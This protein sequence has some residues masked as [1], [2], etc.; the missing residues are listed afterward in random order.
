[1]TIGGERSKKNVPLLRL[2][3]T[4]GRSKKN[5]PLLR[6]V[7]M[8]S[9]LKDIQDTV[10]TY[11]K[12]IS[13]I[14]KVDVEIVDANLYRI[15]GTGVFESKINEDMSCEG[16]VYKTVLETGEP[17]LIEE[18]GN[19]PLCAACPKRQSCEE[20]LELCTPIKLNNEIIGVIGLICFDNEQK[21][22]LLR[23]LDVYREFLDQI[24]GFISIKAY[25][26]KE[27]E[28]TSMLMKLLNV[29]IDNMGKGVLIL[30]K[31]DRIVHING[32][33][34]KQLFLTRDCLQKKINIEATG[35]NI[36]GLDEFKV[37][38]N[39]KVF[40]LMGDML[41]VIP[42]VAEYA[43]IL[44]FNEMKEVKSKIYDLT[45]I[46][47]EIRLDH[48]L[49]EAE[50]M[51]QLK[52]KILKIAESKSTVLITGESG[53]GKELVARAIYTES[54][55]HSQPFVAI[56]CGAIPDTL[57][58]SELFGYVKGA[59]TG[60]DP[61]GKIGKFELANKGVIFLDEVGDMPLYLQVKLLRVLQERKITRIG[62]NQQIDIDVRVIAATNKNLVPMI[63]ENKFR[64]DLYYRL[65][66]IP[67]E[68]PPLRER[69]EDIRLIAMHLIEKYSR[70]FDKKVFGIDEDAI[71]ELI[72]YPWPGNVRELENTIEFM[73]N[74]VDDMGSLT[75]ET[76]PNNIQDYIAKDIP[77]NPVERNY[78]NCLIEADS[79]RPIKE[80]ERMLIQK[81]LQINGDTTEGKQLAAKQLG[82]GIATLYRRI[83][84]YQLSK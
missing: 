60:A 42:R 39:E 31:D 56:N 20:K 82:I 58:E 49:G 43:K 22:H 44:I 16:F 61:R 26:N 14:I 11:A 63:A 24:A 46:A 41:P 64:E 66:V 10:I 34:L 57:L 68:I 47:N 12:I 54:V 4:A 67:L 73:I 83:E 2:K 74:M 38:L 48:I 8:K 21:D 5:V 70:L 45:N 17:Q 59:F 50:V 76:L 80:M 69:K 77:P 71:R 27:N 3:A 78:D 84:E 52:R 35:D 19:H 55:R 65:N 79:I 13:H 28:R 18:P 9:V 29:V 51:R 81:A 15:A 75:K 32:S 37:T 40:Y 36:L 72:D 30:D 1:M 7:I 33:A 62:S 23:E 6:E 25:E 53:T